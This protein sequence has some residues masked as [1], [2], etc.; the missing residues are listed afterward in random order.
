VGS[1]EKIGS[2]GNERDGE[3]VTLERAV[4]LLGLEMERARIEADSIV[5]P[6]R[7]GYLWGLLDGYRRAMEILSGEPMIKP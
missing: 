5:T 1:Q 6:E 7:Q 3:P 2:R 4:E